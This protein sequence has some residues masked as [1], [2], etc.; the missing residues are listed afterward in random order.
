VDHYTTESRDSPAF[1]TRISTQQNGSGYQPYIPAVMTQQV[2]F[3]LTPGNKHLAIAIP[4][5]VLL[6]FPDSP[7]TPCEISLTD[8]QRIDL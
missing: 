3:P 8:Y 2:G 7:P 4:G 1:A 6:V 5:D